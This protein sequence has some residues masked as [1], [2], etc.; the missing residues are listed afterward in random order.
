MD[1]RKINTFCNLLNRINNICSLFKQFT[2]NSITNIVTYINFKDN[3]NFAIQVIRNYSIV[4]YINFKDNHNWH[5]QRI[6]N[7]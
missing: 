1:I 4:T 6:R 3:H 5:L 2:I 7:R